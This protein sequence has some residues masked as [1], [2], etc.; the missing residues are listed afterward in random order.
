MSNGLHTGPRSAR[1][2]AA[3]TV[4][5]G[6]GQ[7]GAGRSPVKPWDPG[8]TW[9]SQQLPGALPSWGTV[10][11]G[12]CPCLLQPCSCL[13][14]RTCAGVKAL[15]RMSQSLSSQLGIGSPEQALQVGLPTLNSSWRGWLPE[16][17]GA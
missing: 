10:G 15:E 6:K 3:V 14:P 8:H 2:Q 16:D 4:I 7:D 12:G 11:S 13:A 1:W 5:V 9:Q 17:P